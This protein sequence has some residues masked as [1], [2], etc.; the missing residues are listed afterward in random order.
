MKFVEKINELKSG[1]LMNKVWN[2][3]ENDLVI[4]ELEKELLVYEE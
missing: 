4:K 1:L 2:H 3:M